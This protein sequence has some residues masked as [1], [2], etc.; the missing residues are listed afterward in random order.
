MNIPTLHS[1]NLFVLA[2]QRDMCGIK[3]VVIVFCPWQHLVRIKVFFNGYSPIDE[4]SWKLPSDFSVSR[5]AIPR[6]CTFMVSSNRNGYFEMSWR[7]ITSWKTKASLSIFWFCW[8][9]TR[10]VLHE[11]KLWSKWPW[12]Y[13]NVGVLAFSL[14]VRNL[15]TRFS[16]EWPRSIQNPFERGFIKETFCPWHFCFNV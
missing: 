12:A 2:G 4:V 16:L 14:C 10:H 1:P 15:S 7:N 3:T 13:C 9:C 11:N 5:Q 6:K 8:V